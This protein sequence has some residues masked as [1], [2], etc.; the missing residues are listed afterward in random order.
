[1][2]RFVIA[3]N[4]WNHARVIRYENRPFSSKQ[5]M[6]EFMIMKWNS[7]VTP[8]D[9][10]YHLG[11]VVVGDV[12]SP[13]IDLK[14]YIENLS[15]RLNG[16]IILIMG[17]HDWNKRKFYNQLDWEIHPKNIYLEE[18]GS[19][20]AIEVLYTR[21]LDCHDLYGGLGKVSQRQI[22]RLD[23]GTFVVQSTSAAT[24]AIRQNG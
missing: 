14:E 4:H 19:F 13:P 1:M 9:T 5:E 10:V 11:D 3:D 15:I 17:N 21:V 18:G 2:K 23:S 7:V 22:G 8:E 20:F 6:D 24:S 16:H 12:D